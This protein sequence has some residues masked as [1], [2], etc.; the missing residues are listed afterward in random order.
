MGTAKNF[1]PST[2]TAAGRLP[3]VCAKLRILQFCCRERPQ[4]ETDFQA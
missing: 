2:A 1:M 3:R 4:T